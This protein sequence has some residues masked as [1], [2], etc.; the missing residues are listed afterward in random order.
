MKTLITILTFTILLQSCV[1]SS[2]PVRNSRSVKSS[3][4]IVKSKARS[5]REF[6]AFS[7]L[8]VGFMATAY[9]LVGQ[10]QEK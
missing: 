1:S 3:K 10:E 4:V 2:P 9:I 8:F 6:T 7:V 5:R